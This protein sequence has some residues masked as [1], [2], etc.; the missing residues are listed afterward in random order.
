MKNTAIFSRQKFI[1]K[2]VLILDIV[3]ENNVF[4]NCLFY[5]TLWLK[6]YNTIYFLNSTQIAAYIRI[7]LFSLEQDL[8]Y[9]IRIVLRP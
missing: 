5:L 8:S 4:S 3:Q 9:N 6:A 1:L 2:F 7:I